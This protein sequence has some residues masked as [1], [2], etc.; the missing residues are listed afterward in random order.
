MTRKHMVYN[1]LGASLLLTGAIVWLSGVNLGELAVAQ[2]YALA[3]AIKAAARH[4]VSLPVWA[5]ALL[6]L[7]TVWLSSVTARAIS[8][9]YR[10]LVEWRQARRLRPRRARRAAAAA[11]E[12]LPED[13]GNA[14]AQA[15]EVDTLPGP[16]HPVR[17]GYFEDALFG[18]VWRW[19]DAP[20]ADELSPHCAACDEALVP[21]ASGG[22]LSR[23]LHCARCNKLRAA[24]EHPDEI[25]DKVAATLAERKR[26]GEWR[27][28]PRRV[29]GARSAAT[30]PLATLPAA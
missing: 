15:P 19:A 22:S 23:G 1:T 6:C 25:F 8:N 9:A 11:Q 27:A 2:S 16:L 3:D 28:A 7:P 10:S 14:P 13:E 17:D 30:R 20:E 4:P 26:T 29:E 21:W 12:P 5:V 24:G 18:V